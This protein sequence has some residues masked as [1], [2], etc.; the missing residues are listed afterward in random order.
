MNSLFTELKRR[1][2]IKVGVFY[3]VACWLIIQVAETVLPLFDVPEGV[4]RGLVI[5]LALGAV[6]TLAMSWIYELTPEGVKR[7]SEIEPGESV[8]GHTGRKLNLATLVVAILAIGLMAYDRFVPPQEASQA[9]T[10]VQGEETLDLQH[11]EQSDKDEFV[12]IAV[13]PF[14]NMSASQ[15]QEYFSDG[16]TEEIINALVKLPDLSVAA[17][18]S[19][20][21]FKNHSEDIRTVGQKLGVNH[22]LEGSVRSDGSNVRITAQLIKVDDGFHLWSDTFD[23]ELVSVFAIQDEIARA[24]ADQLAINLTD[25]SDS[26]PNRTTSM[27]A[28]DLYL[29]GR[30]LLRQRDRGEAKV[31]L[32]QST[33]RDPKF[34]P[35]WAALAITLQVPGRLAE[36]EVAA[37][38][39]LAID[40]HNVDA[41]DAL[42]SVYRDRFEWRQ[43]QT[44]YERAL[45]LDPLSPELLEDYAEFLGSVG[46]FEKM[47][48]ITSR[49]YRV[50]PL[51]GPLADVHISALILNGRVEEALNITRTTE[52]QI[53]WIGLRQFQILVAKNQLDLASRTALQIRDEIGKVSADTGAFLDQIILVLENPADRSL[54]RPLISAHHK[55]FY[56][57]HFVWIVLSAAGQHEAVLES[58]LTNLGRNEG[59]FHEWYWMPEFAAMRALP[60]FAEIVEILKLPVYW[61]Q[62][63]WPEFC[64]RD[65]Q[66]MIT[67]H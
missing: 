27:D 14:V 34:A 35:A 4:L 18:T 32:T 64:A 23:R 42:A 3:L 22:I 58:M 57:D 26:V 52:L 59:S 40:P 60:G 7:E 10:V 51:L 12:S 66:G 2:V 46:Q 20:F 33:Q 55:S 67:C 41:L 9:P 63:G 47:L 16:M 49:G 39:A 65:A 43:A 5:L 25:V 8:T 31:W 21:A 45:S 24:I 11:E 56:D 50:D 28:Y 54:D 13:L 15:D 37:N 1:N 53:W 36:A 30:A 61:D 62:V 19:V 48:E 17:R 44:T 38:T 6:P 29:K